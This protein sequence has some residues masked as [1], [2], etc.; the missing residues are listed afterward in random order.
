MNVTPTDGESPP[1]VKS[2]Q[3]T[4]RAA[5]ELEKLR[6]EVETA[7]ATNRLEADKLRL[8]IQQIKRTTGWWHISTFVP[9]FVGLATLF[10]GLILNHTLNYA[11][12]EQ[13][14]FENYTKLTDEFS[15]G[16][17]AKLGAI[18]GFRP[19]LRPWADR[20]DQT[21]ELLANELLK[22]QD[23]TTRRAIVQDLVYAG[24]PAFNHVRDV[25]IVTREKLRKSAIQL[26]FHYANVDKAHTVA[27]PSCNVYMVSGE[28]RD[29]AG[30]YAPDLPQS[31]QQVHRDCLSQFVYAEL[32]DWGP[33]GVHEES[34]HP[35]QQARREF[36]AQAPA[37]LASVDVLRA[38][39]WQ[40]GADLR[41]FDASGIAVFDMDL[42]DADLQG[43]NLSGSVV[44][45]SANGADLS[46]ADLSN[47]NLR[48]DLGRSITRSTSLCGANILYAK[49][50]LS[51]RAEFPNLTAANWWDI[52]DDLTGSRVPK[53]TRD[54]EAAFPRKR[55]EPF[56][57]LQPDAKKRLCAETP[58]TQG[59]SAGAVESFRKFVSPMR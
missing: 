56:A 10:A 40:P 44:E 21:V 52:I 38:L 22:E 51:S 55:S 13:H 50:K 17:S 20:S 32:G 49:L 12:D 43:I 58:Y 28:A 39:L 54:L 30:Q 6:L 41:N 26:M 18:V 59:G 1:V 34:Q 24:M 37:F 27:C 53:N 8:E 36:Y 9:L 33:V 29:A 7:R 11:A 48:A 25:N 46:N 45:G 15:K 42:R 2:A 47:A 23:P 3:E 57:T 5:L 31:V 14:A 35:W 16:G 4:E 19:F